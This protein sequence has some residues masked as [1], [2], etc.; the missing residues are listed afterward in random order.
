MSLEEDEELTGDALVRRA[1]ELNALHDL[2][3]GIST[4]QSVREVIESSLLYI[5]GV[6]GLRSGLISIYRDDEAEPRESVCRGIQRKTAIRWSQEL[7]AHLE[8]LYIHEECIAD[9]GSDSPLAELL[10]SYRFRVWL[11][12]KVDDHT[13][14]GIALGE[15]L[16][17]MAFTPDDREL[18][19]TLAISIQN[20]LSNVSLI[21][22]LHQAFTKETRIRNIFQR[23]APEL[24]VNEVLNPSNEELLMGESEAVRHMV[25]DM[26]AGWEEQNRLEQDLGMAH[27]VQQ[28]LLPSEAPQMEG[29]HLAA[30]SIPARGVCGDL[31]DFISLSPH[32]IGIS[33]ADI[34]GKGM[35]AAMIATMLQS[36]IRMCV[37]SYY[38][39][40]AIL[41]ILNRFM[42]RHTEAYRYATIFYGQ[43]NTQERIL[44]YSNAGHPPA[45]LWRDGKLHP[46]DTEGH[47]VGIFEHSNYYQDTIKLQ[48]N[49]A[50]VIYS[51]G[52]TDAGTTPE[53]T[54]PADAF[55]QERL[56]ATIMAN[57][58]LSAEALLDAISEKVTKYAGSGKQFDDITLIVM[59]VE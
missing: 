37:G 18:L 54:D 11:P 2:N 16:S 5:R 59:K 21:E 42:Y 38:P 53:S 30:R 12:L 10:K 19:S 6:L 23:Y 26:I 58:S 33:L 48:S 29:I 25:D 46:L 35:S 36:A 47:P 50:L 28:Y 27:E 45:I 56:E 40:H 15:K 52:V 17:E 43:V 3:K 32:E 20:V 24:V 57:A 55:G 4:L 41:S 8:E 9:G 1:Y 22:A 44:T 34:A 31:Y 51:D 7:K 14:G 13:W 39:I 49:D